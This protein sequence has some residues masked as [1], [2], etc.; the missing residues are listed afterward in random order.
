MLNYIIFL[1]LTV[2]V[3]DR[4][5]KVSNKTAHDCVLVFEFFRFRDTSVRICNR[6]IS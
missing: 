6:F 1:F 2:E 4:V 5:D 3:K